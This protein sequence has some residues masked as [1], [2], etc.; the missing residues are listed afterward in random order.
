MCVCRGG[1]RGSHCASS[2]STPSQSVKMLYANCFI[3]LPQ[4]GRYPSL[5]KGGGG[6]ALIQCDLFRFVPS[7][8]FPT[9]FPTHFLP[10]KSES[11]P[12]FFYL[13]GFWH[14][15]QF[16][17]VHKP[18]VQFKT[19]NGQQTKTTAKVWRE[20]QQKETTVWKC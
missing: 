16:L 14:H 19:S 18:L 20:Y 13:C 17:K 5:K 4:V 1:G 7:K 3:S 9:Q 8:Q 10:Q 12:V 6:R 2:L 11:S 15:L